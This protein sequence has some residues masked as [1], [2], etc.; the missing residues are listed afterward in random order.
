MSK[1]VYELG[2]GTVLD[3]YNLIGV[4]QEDIHLGFI[5]TSGQYLED[6]LLGTSHNYLPNTSMQIESLLR[7]FYLQ[8]CESFGYDEH[9]LKMKEQYFKASRLLMALMMELN[10]IPEESQE[11]ALGFLRT[12]SLLYLALHGILSLPIE[13]VI[14]LGKLLSG[15][16]SEED[17]LSV[18]NYLFSVKA[19]ALFPVLL[20]LKGKY[21]E[22]Y[23]KD[24]EMF[25][26]DTAQID[27]EK[28]SQMIGCNTGDLVDISIFDAPAMRPSFRLCLKMSSDQK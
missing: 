19:V 15:C 21:K 10:V 18:K 24:Y 26:K 16:A 23:E 1:C 25:N 11:F 27:I 22:S 3:Y 9:S 13:N 14:E 5:E 2:I 28:L 7:N 17:Y 4:D 20:A 6:F 12:N 8:M